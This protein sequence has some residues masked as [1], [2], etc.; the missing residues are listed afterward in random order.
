MYPLSGTLPFGSASVSNAATATQPMGFGHQNNPWAGTVGHYA[1]SLLGGAFGGPFGAIGGG[2][3]GQN[4]GNAAGNIFAG[5]DA[6]NGSQGN[7]WDNLN[8]ASRYGLMSVQQGP[9]PLLTGNNQGIG[10]LFS[11][12]GA[13]GGMNPLSGLLG[14]H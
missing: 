7:F 9:I 11:G 2:I 5:K 1:G 4:A 8:P 12:S 10:Q 6:Y 3:V 14:G 13:M